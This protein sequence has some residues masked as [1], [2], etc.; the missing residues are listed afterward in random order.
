MSH[1][2]SGPDSFPESW[3]GPIKVISMC[4][5]TGMRWAS[6]RLAG[7]SASPV[8]VGEDRTPYGVVR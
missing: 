5:G 8:L 4:D 7:Q 6:E 1:A 2:V 3:E